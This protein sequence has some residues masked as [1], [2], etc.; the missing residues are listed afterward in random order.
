M[1]LYTIIL[2]NIV[3]TTVKFEERKQED[4]NLNVKTAYSHS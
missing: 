1:S 4:K 3:T 2:V